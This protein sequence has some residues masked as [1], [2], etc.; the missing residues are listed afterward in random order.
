[1]GSEGELGMSDGCSCLSGFQLL[2]PEEFFTNPEGNMEFERTTFKVSIAE[3]ASRSGGHWFL[4]SR[5]PE[6]PLVNTGGQETCQDEKGS[7]LGLVGLESGGEL[8]TWTGDIVEQL[9]L[10][11]E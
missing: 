9:K 8:L 1:M 10:H 5:K 11:F 4:S 6:N 7:L 3:V 2:P